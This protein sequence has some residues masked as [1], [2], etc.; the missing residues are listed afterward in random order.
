[1]AES[2]TTWSPRTVGIALAAYQP[3]PGWLAEQL[4]SITEQTHTDW[5]CVLTFDSPMSEVSGDQRLAPYL[6]DPRFTWVQ[7]EERLGVRKNFEKAASLAAALGVDLIA[8]SDQDDVWLPEKLAISVATIASTG[9]LTLVHTD[10]FLLVN[11]ELLSETIHSTHRITGSTLKIEEIIIYPSVSGYLM[12]LDADLVRR[13][14]SIPEPMRYHDHWYSVVATSYGGVTRINE[15]LAFDRQHENNTV[16]ISSVRVTNGLSAVKA[17]A[18]DHSSARQR[19]LWHIGSARQC[20]VE[21]PMNGMKRFL[22][23]YPIGWALLMLSIIARRSLSERLLVVQAYRALIGQLLVFP[24]QVE[25][26]TRIR[27]R[28]PYQGKLLRL[29]VLLFCAALG[30]SVVLNRTVAL[31]AVASAAPLLWFGFAAI[32]LVGPAWRLAR[33]GYPHAGHVLVGLSA[34]AAGLMRVVTEDIALSLL[35]FALPVSWY[36]AYRIRWR[37]DAGF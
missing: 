25:R 20:A 7:N 12:V 3:N 11:G 4:A 6:R 28:V 34:V 8:F 29:V 9:P 26:G 13:H 15:P 23:H 21:L 30:T 33:H 14:P 27:S 2:A 19:G 10:A 36:L 1:M 31:E 35:A 16:G 32:A 5:H 18:S 24:S 17:K 37:G 22:M